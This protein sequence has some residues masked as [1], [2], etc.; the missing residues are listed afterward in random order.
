M[1]DEFQTRYNVTAS[2]A[3]HAQTA[4]RNDNGRVNGIK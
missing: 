1:T 2:R 4:M 3:A